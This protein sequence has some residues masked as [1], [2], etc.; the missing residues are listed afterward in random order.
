[1]YGKLIILSFCGL[2]AATP[3]YAENDFFVDFSA[4]DSLSGAITGVGEEL[5]FPTVE[6][7]LATPQAAA[8]RV[9]K[10]KDVSKVSVPVA[11]KAPTTATLPQAKPA[12]PA[13]AKP[14]TENIELPQKPEI[15]LPENAIKNAKALPLEPELK[16]EVI[17][18]VENP[19]DA[20]ATPT[21]VRP[22][23][24]EPTLKNIL[25]QQTTPAAVVAHPAPAAP[26]IEPLIDEND[27]DDTVGSFVFADNSYDVTP[28][29]KLQLDQAVKGFE[30]PMVNKILIVAYNYDKDNGF[31]SKHICLK[32]S[33]GLRSYLLNQGYKNF[34]IK[35]INTDNPQQKDLVEVS[36]IK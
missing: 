8:P 7:Q 5:M 17:A 29:M 27:A 6:P 35:I 15:K 2:L 14:A 13:I 26:K 32:R 21:P 24:S 28:A 3:A 23:A 4:L 25:Q 18:A 30:N 33:T 22:P 1:M 34:S 10:T 31:M 20:S 16:R 19:E 9:K 11:A 36:E 12:Q